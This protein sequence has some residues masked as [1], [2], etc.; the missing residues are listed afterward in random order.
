[1]HGDRPQRTL[2]ASGAAFVTGTAAHGEDFE[3]YLRGRP[4]ACRRGDRGR[5][6]WL[7]AKS[8]IPMRRMALIGIAVGTEVLCG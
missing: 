5:R 4:G 2:N 1:M 8:I 7:P 3:R 6:F